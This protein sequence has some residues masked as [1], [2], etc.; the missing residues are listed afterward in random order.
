MS[1][2]TQHFIDR[3][4]FQ[5]W[6]EFSTPSGDV[7]VELR[8]RNATFFRRDGAAFVR[9]GQR[10]VTMHVLASCERLYLTLLDLEDDA[11]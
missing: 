11:R 6:K 4:P 10:R 1:E 8:G 5:G 2:A 3:S 9:V 7:R